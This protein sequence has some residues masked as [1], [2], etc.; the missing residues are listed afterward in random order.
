MKASVEKI[1]DGVADVGFMIQEGVYISV[2]HN[3]L[4]SGCRC[5][6]LRCGRR[7]EQPLIQQVEIDVLQTFRVV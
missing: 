1:V 2:V 7:A 3:D 5:L 4:C 6:L